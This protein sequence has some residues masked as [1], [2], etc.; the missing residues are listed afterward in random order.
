MVGL[1]VVTQAAEVDDAADA[2]CFGGSSEAFGQL[3]VTSTKVL[4]TQRVH[5]IES[6]FAS[7]QRFPEG[8]PVGHVNRPTRGTGD[9][10]GTTRERDN[11]V[12]SLDKGNR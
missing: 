12:A 11:L 5:E 8:S 1:R 3:A 2:H 10:R 6:D 7:S 4:G 9:L